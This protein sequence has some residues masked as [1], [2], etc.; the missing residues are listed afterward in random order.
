MS[1]PPRPRLTA[2]SP[3]DRAWE[4]VALAIA[5]VAVA[6]YLTVTKLSGTP[7]LLCT[8]GSPCEIVQE[9]RYAM[10]LGVPTALW[11]AALFAA[12]G[13]LA[14][15]P[16]TPARWLWSFALAAAGVAFSAYLTV[17]AL[18]GLRAA[19]GWCLASGVLMLAL[20]GALL[21]RRPPPGRRRAWLRPARLAVLGVVVAAVTVVGAVG[22][23]LDPA[24][25]ATEEQQTLA[26]HLAQTGARF[27]G[28]YWCPACRRQKELFGGAAELLPY[29]ECD[30]RGAR[31]RP[32]ACAAAGVK[33]YPTWTIRGQR[34]EGVLSLDQL[35]RASGFVPP[36]AASR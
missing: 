21:W 1:R 2:P 18:A 28:A 32:E 33:S 7:P 4:V 23:F 17:I 36:P 14:A 31:A 22:V 15:W 12:I 10:F 27:Y 13:I 30:S 26:R 9:S 5:G 29:V 34:H 8:T 20:L 25:S 6:G 16:Y 11:G 3:P 19:C 24:S 35:A